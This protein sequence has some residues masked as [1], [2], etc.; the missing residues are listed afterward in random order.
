MFL[1]VNNDYCLILKS[2]FQVLYS[3]FL[4]LI[5]KEVC[6]LHNLLSLQDLLNSTLTVSK[7]TSEIQQLLETLMDYSMQEQEEFLEII[8]RLNNIVKNIPEREEDLTR[9]SFK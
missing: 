6:Y 5:V 3:L 7:M 9:W 8:H 4:L 1:N 2:D